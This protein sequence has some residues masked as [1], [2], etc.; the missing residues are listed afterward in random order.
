MALSW[1][2]AG[3]VIAGVIL[4][5]LL[6]ASLVV[7]DVDY[8]SVLQEKYDVNVSDASLINQQLVLYLNGQ[9]DVPSVF[10]EDEVSHL[11]DIQQIVF[12]AGLLFVFLL[13]FWLFL[14]MYSSF[15]KIAVL[16]W[17]GGISIVIPLLLL[18]VPF[19]FSFSWFHV[20]LFPYGSWLFS[21]EQM[22]IRL[23][24]FGF[25]RDFGVRIFLQSIIFGIVLVSS[26][27]LIKNRLF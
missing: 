2:E 17:V 8:Y 11:K 18:I 20:F 3:M 25:F 1:F 27:K 22:L 24:P 4:V 15:D 9:D 5:Y 13:V 19:S 16:Q 10:S 21:P 14:F 23:Y 7:F 26:K 12:K 6:S